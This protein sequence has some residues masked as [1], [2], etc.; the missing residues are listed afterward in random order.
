[1]FQRTEIERFLRAVD[2]A[3]TKRL[4]LIV[5]GGSAATLHCGAARATQDIDTLT[6]VRAP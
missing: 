5:I 1:M 3:L 2:K 4:E 6:S